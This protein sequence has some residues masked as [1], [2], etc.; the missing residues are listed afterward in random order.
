MSTQDAN[1][2]NSDVTYKRFQDNGIPTVRLHLPNDELSTGTQVAIGP[3]QMEY[4]PPTR[5]RVAQVVAECEE[6]M[7]Q[8]VKIQVGDILRVASAKLYDSD[9]ST[10]TRPESLFPHALL[11]EVLT[12]DRI[13]R[14]LDSESDKPKYGAYAINDCVSRIRGTTNSDQL[15]DFARVFATLLLCRKEQDIFQ[16][17]QKGLDDKEFPFHTGYNKEYGIP[18]SLCPNTQIEDVSDFPAGWE[19]AQCESFV[20][21]QCKVFLPCF[22]HGKHHTFQKEVIMPWYD[23]HLPRTGSWPST[24]SSSDGGTSAPG[25]ANSEV[26]RVII[27]D[28]HHRFT[29]LDQVGYETPVGNDYLNL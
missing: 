23:Y 19:S 25:G 7:R 5:Q 14:S 26:S 20:M 8:G 29:G 12:E 4:T 9:G 24:L 22:E 21:T 13:T 3:P 18:C 28:G 15:G 11:A 16:F 17:F 1:A 27:H 6:I 10:G 2:T